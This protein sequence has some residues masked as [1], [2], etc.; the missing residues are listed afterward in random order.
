MGRKLALLF[1]LL[2][3]GATVETA[4]SVKHQ[5]AVGF[6]PEGCRVIAG[7]FYGPSFTFEAEATRPLPE[8]SAVSVDNAFG[9]VNVGTGPSP[10]VRVRLRKRVYR[11]TQEEAEA[12]ARRIEIVLEESAEGLR[13]TTN[14]ETLSREDPHIGF[15]TD[16]EITLPAHAR[17]TLKNEHGP[18]EARD[19]AEAR[20]DSSFDSLLLERV[21]GAAE[22]QHRHGDVEVNEIGGA[23]KLVA[24]HGDVTVRGTAGTAEVDVEHGD[25]K[26]EGTAGLRVKQ[27]HGDVDVTTVAGDLEV[28][29]THSEVRAHHVT[30]TAR[31]STAFNSLEVG[32]VGGDATLRAEHGQI[33]ARDVKGALT[34]DARFDGVELERIGGPVEVRV[35]HGGVKAEDLGQGV[36]ITSEGDAVHLVRVKGPVEVKAE[37]GEVT[38]EPAGP[39]TEPVSI[40]TTHGAIHLTVPADSR[41]ELEASARHGD[42]EVDLPGAPSVREDAALRTLSMSLGGG[43]AKVRLR[44]QN[45]EVT[46]SSHAERASN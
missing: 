37:R 40:E 32:D 29:A 10:E 8:G 15:E 38:L 22:I 14:R 35:E 3:F 5:V 7:R 30:G 20:I 46:V 18:V 6:G 27:A 43:G 4:W 21:A 9:A 16:L 33:E 26:A 31:L 2:G 11:S 19:V 1:L 41:F 44:A 42:L 45:G 13:V 24:R 17:L 36:K 23:L 34:V 25:V 12:F 39:L 28:E